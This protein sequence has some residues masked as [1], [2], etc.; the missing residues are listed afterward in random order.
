MEKKG[1]KVGQ[2]VV[3]KN[4]E[5]ISNGTKGKV[6]EPSPEDT[7]EW[8]PVLFECFSHLVMSMPPEELEIVH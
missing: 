6:V 3:S 1:F 7:K 2:I 8:I 5:L 4:C